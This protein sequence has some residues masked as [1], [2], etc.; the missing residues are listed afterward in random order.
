MLNPLCTKTVAQKKK[1]KRDVNEM[2]FQF[3]FICKQGFSTVQST[4]ASSKKN[5]LHTLLTG[6]LETHLLKKTE[7]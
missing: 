1:K 5:S 4:K 2:L 7:G 3:R 6:K